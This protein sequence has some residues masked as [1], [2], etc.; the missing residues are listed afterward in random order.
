[1]SIGDEW[2]QLTSGED[3]SMV[4]GVGMLGD[5]DGE[6]EGKDRWSD[7]NTLLVGPDLCFSSLIAFS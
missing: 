6:K 1:M 2:D 5:D 3:Q 4:M 7:L